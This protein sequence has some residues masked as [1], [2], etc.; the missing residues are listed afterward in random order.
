M[1]ARGEEEQT[2]VD[3]GVLDVLFTSGCQFLSQVSRVLIF[4]VLDNRFPAKK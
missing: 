2:T 1:T 3:S 4:D